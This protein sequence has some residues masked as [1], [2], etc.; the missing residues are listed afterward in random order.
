MPWSPEYEARLLRPGPQGSEGVLS[1]SS[2]LSTMWSYCYETAWPSG[3][4]HGSTAALSMVLRVR[5]P[6]ETWMSVSC[7]CCVLSGRGLC[8]RPI[9]RQEGSYQAWCVWVWSRDLIEEPI[10]SVEPW[11]KKSLW[12]EGQAYGM[13][14]PE[15]SWI[16][17]SVC[18]GTV[19]ATVLAGFTFMS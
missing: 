16:M 4:R 5:F 11:K 6:P 17:V 9:T 13:F 1:H 18:D 19:C 14:M 10:R 3:L 15:G 7:E 8:D 2:E 12:N